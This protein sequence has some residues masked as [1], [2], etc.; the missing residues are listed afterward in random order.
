[1]RS[2]GPAA[3]KGA[4]FIGLFAAAGMAL[5]GCAEGGFARAEM[6]TSPPP[7]AASMAVRFSP[8]LRLMPAPLLAKVASAP[9]SPQ[10]EPLG[11]ETPVLAP[12]ALAEPQG[13][14]S[15]TLPSG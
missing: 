13:A 6:A 14:R 5:P 3:W 12:T 1:M 9:A 15:T 2:I 8:G 4:G 7:D 10:V 11:R